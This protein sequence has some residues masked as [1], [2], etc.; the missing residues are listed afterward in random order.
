MQDLD[1]GAYHEEEE[2]AGRQVLSVS[3]I[4][5][6]EWSTSHS[7]KLGSNDYSP[8]LILR[9]LKAAPGRHLPVICC[10]RYNYRTPP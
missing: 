4:V 2:Q 6:V 7:L 1:D 5:A 3:D 9:T 8:A 10:Y